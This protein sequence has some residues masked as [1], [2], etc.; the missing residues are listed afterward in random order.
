MLTLW[1][2]GLCFCALIASIALVFSGQKKG[3]YF[4]IVCAYAL[5]AAAAILIAVVL[6]WP[7]ATKTTTIGATHNWQQVRVEP[8]VN[9]IEE[10][11]VPVGDNLPP[12]RRITQEKFEKTTWVDIL[13]GVHVETT[14][15]PHREI[16]LIQQE[17]K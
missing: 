4:V 8:V 11:V 9:I 15:A 3:G 10:K 7:V 5:A 14:S 2:A 13:N 12:V 1:T 17:V 16:I 6:S